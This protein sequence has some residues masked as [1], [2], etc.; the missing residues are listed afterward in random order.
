MLKGVSIKVYLYN[1]NLI[2]SLLK[3]LNQF[4]N[5]TIELSACEHNFYGKC[6]KC[7]RYYTSPEWCKSCDPL[8][9]T[10]KRTSENKDID[11]YI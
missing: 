4:M 8:K 2:R 6:T 7:K 9:V 1:Q 10:Q 3:F 5:M 11:N